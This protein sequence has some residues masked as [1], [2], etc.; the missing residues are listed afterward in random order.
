MTSRVL[1]PVGSA[2]R[3]ALMVAA[4]AASSPPL[5]DEPVFLVSP[6][7]IEFYDGTYR[8]LKPPRA[9]A[10]SADGLHLGYSYCPEYR[11]YLVP[12]ARDLAMQACAKAGGKGCR[13][14]AVNDDIKVNYRVMLPESPIVSPET[15]KNAM[16]KWTEA[17]VRTCF[18]APK[19]TDVVAGWQRHRFQ[20][21]A[22]TAYVMFKDGNVHSVEGYGSEPEC[23]R[24]VEIC[25]K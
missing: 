17:D 7:V 1:N 5:A 10:V 18:G 12:S 20:R 13:V 9:I 16:L 14:F 24:V 4:I 3:A 21:D 6:Q 22:C 11:C 25:K 15:A 19:D 23:R 2:G 8:N